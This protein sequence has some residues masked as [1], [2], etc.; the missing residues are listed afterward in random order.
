MLGEGPCVP[1]RPHGS[2]LGGMGEIFPFQP[3][4]E[5]LEGRVGVPPG[6][7]ELSGGSGVNPRQRRGPGGQSPEV[8]AIAAG[9]FAQHA[10]QA[11]CQDTRAGAP[12]VQAPPQRRGVP[13]HPP[14]QAFEP[15]GQ[16]LRV[17]GIGEW[18]RTQG[19]PVHRR[20]GGEPGVQ[21]HRPV[22]G[23]GRRQPGLQPVAHHRRGPPVRPVTQRRAV[24]RVEP[25]PE[26]LGEPGPALRTPVRQPSRRPRQPV[27]ESLGRLELGPAAHEPI[28]NAVHQTRSRHHKQESDRP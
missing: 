13:L 26:G 22:L 8:A 1:L 28:G 5:L 18:C 17:A 21:L 25:V 19:D 9:A 4:G 7:G 14:R 6:G 24:E 23:R 15:S 20:R 11:F 16:Q 3:V 27:G 12:L 2:I 10:D